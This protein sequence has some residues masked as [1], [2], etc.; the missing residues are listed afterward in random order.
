MASKLVNDA[1]TARLAANWTHCVV[2][3]SD[4]QADAPQDSSA[5][6]S[7]QYP[8]VTEQHITLG[9]V[10]QRTFRELGTIRF[11]LAVPRGTG[12]DIGGQWVDDLRN[13]FRAAQFGGVHCEGASPAASD[14]LNANGNYY[15]MRVIVPYWADIFA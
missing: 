8:T 3:G 7:V 10:G 5:F 14:G 12:V 1:V 15:L 13:L 11:V 9:P 6:L 4:V 2:I